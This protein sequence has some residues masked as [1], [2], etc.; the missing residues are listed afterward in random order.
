MG[1]FGNQRE[2]AWLEVLTQTLLQYFICFLACSHGHQLLQE[3]INQFRLMT[4]AP[5]E[6][7]PQRHYAIFA[8]RLAFFSEER[9]IDLLLQ[10]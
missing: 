7:F 9:G 1:N 3:C 4:Q 6:F 10:C 2:Q 5:G 8:Q